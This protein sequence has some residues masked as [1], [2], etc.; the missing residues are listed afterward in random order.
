[1]LDLVLV[2]VASLLVDFQRLNTPGRTVEGGDWQQMLQCVCVIVTGNEKLKV[3]NE[4][5]TNNFPV[6]GKRNLSK[7]LYCYAL[8]IIYFIFLRN[9]LLLLCKLL[10]IPRN[11]CCGSAMIAIAVPSPLVTC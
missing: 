10:G 9:S 3:I 5:E 1:M 4:T 11:N 8:M 2:D 7:V 6:L